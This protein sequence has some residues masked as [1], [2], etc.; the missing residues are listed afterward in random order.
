MPHE[1]IKNLFSEA[2][3]SVASDIS[4]YAIHPSKDFKRNKKILPDKL[5]SFLVFCGSSSTKIELL[6]FFGL[7]SHAPS[8][9]AFNQQ[10]AKLRPEW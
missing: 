3:S 6:G 4:R 10:R 9:S 1:K 2:V 8:S 5:I 7:D